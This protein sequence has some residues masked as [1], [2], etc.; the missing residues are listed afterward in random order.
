M[1]HAP[2]FIPNIPRYHKFS[3][4]RICS[5][6][7]FFSTVGQNFCAEN[8]DTPSLHSPF[9]IHNFLRHPKLVIH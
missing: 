7:K 3:E 1:I 2:S 9:L 6:T 8:R 4:A 5:L